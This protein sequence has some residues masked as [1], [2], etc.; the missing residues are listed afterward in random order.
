[1]V[2]TTSF[3]ASIDESKG[4]FWWKYL[5]KSETTAS[6][7]WLWTVSDLAL[8]T[9]KMKVGRK[10]FIISAKVLNEIS[11]IIA[12]DDDAEEDEI[13]ISMGKKKATFTI[14]T[15]EVD[16]A[17]HGRRVHHVQGYHPDSGYDKM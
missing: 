17:P 12:E 8:S 13:S 1:M 14:D 10:H 6:L 15:T 5:Q 2:R 4:S 16:A 3:A 11:K 9:E 7:W